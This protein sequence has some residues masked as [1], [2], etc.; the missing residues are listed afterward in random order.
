M[1]ADAAVGEGME[2]AGGMAMGTEPL[3][4]LVSRLVALRD[5]IWTGVMGTELV[6]GFTGK[7]GS[8]LSS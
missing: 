2:G 8:K 3:A 7:A 4:V 6:S 1:G 5:W